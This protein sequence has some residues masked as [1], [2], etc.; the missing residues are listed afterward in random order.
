MADEKSQGVGTATEEAPG[1]NIVQITFLP[2]G[3]TVT[4]EHAR[5]HA[6]GLATRPKEVHGER[7]SP[8][9]STLAEHID[10]ESSGCATLRFSVRMSS[11]VPHRLF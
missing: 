3:K 1:E 10:R 7:T 11:D 5:Q 9:P 4:F 8:E 6:N 2:E